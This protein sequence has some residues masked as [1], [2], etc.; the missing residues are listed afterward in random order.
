MVKAF[1]L[2]IVALFILSACGS[3]PPIEGASEMPEVSPVPNSQIPITHSPSPSPTPEASVMPNSEPPIPSSP[4]PT[5]EISERPAWEDVI[6]FVCHY[7]TFSETIGLFDVAILEPDRMTAPQVAWLGERG[8]WTIGYV[9][10]GE[11]HNL[12]RMDGGGPGGWASFYIDDGNGE[13]R[14]N[15]N[16]QSY[17]VDAGHP[18]WQQIVIDRVH[19]VL[20]MGFDGVFLD[21]IDTAELIPE[22]REGMADLIRKLRL[23]FPD[24]KIIANRG[25]FMMED[26]AP[27][28]SG[29]MFESFTGGYNFAR[30]EYYTW[31]GND[32]EWTRQRANDI[33]RI[34]QTH[35]FPVFA[36][37]YADPNDLETIQAL[38]DRAWEFDFLPAVS[39]IQLNRVFWRDIQPQTRRG[40]H[41]GLPRWQG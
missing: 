34:R 6:S 18:M 39:V 9:T 27:Y 23:T 22:T 12:R 19:T 31:R 33:N 4:P 35:Y 1:V 5:P 2:L 8:T 21:T 30:Q 28:I 25:F 15:A 26:F 14:Q 24:A 7:G 11:D 32:L 36:L 40:I 16:W 38:Y 20:R 29:I 17:Y 41:S 37:D 13:P 10:V 3:H